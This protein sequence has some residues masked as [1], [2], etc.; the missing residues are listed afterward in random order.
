MLKTLAAGML[1]AMA[2]GGAAFAQ[3]APNEPELDVE[4]LREGLTAIMEAEPG[5]QDVQTAEELRELRAAMDELS[6]AIGDG[7]DADP[8]LKLLQELGRED[9]DPTPAELRRLGLG[10]DA[11]MGQA[12]AKADE[13][14]DALAVLGGLYDQGGRPIS[15]FAAA[16]AVF[17]ADLSA[18]QDDYRL[19]EFIATNGQRGTASDVGQTIRNTA[20][21]FGAYEGQTGDEAAQRKAI[22][23]LLGGDD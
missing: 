2:L 19:L 11:L 1:G 18:V 16:A 23:A 13:R 8:T 22:E 4:T 3:D 20:S 17:G 9:R 14:A 7:P 21:A 15:E 12:G 10:L 6:R 5:A